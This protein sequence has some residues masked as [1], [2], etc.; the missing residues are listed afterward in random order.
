MRIKSF[1][2]QSGK[3]VN[4][5]GSISKSENK[6]MRKILYIIVS[7]IITIVGKTKKESDIEAYYRKN[8]IKVNIIT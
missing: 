8:V 2:K 3:L 4:V 6:Y 7:N 5:H 1:I